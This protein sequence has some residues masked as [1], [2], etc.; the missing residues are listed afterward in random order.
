MEPEESFPEFNIDDEIDLEAQIYDE[1]QV[2]EID[3]LESEHNSID[4]NN[5][6]ESGKLTNIENN[7]S[8]PK[9][10]PTAPHQHRYDQ[11]INEVHAVS[12]NI[13]CFQNFVNGYSNIDIVVNYDNS[14]TQLLHDRPSLYSSSIVLENG[15]Q[16]FISKRVS[17]TSAILSSTFR[18][19]IPNL[20][21]RS[22][23]EL[24]TESELKKINRIINKNQV[25]IPRSN[26]FLTFM[27]DKSI[28][29]DAH[30][31]NT[32]EKLWVD[33]Y[34]PTNFSQVIFHTL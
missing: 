10:N 24:T 11:S 28:S 17:D 22:M 30:N 31:S 29:V 34:S 2:D 6:T 13:G 15:S 32:Y 3:Y 33:K 4:I 21:S 27:K 16:K 7:Y 18:S 14:T 20:L 26:I 25:I 5:H 23:K 19:E 9:T 8:P 1:I 12:K